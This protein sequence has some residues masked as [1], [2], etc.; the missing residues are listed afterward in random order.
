[1]IW[2]CYGEV[3]GEFSPGLIV[4]RLRQFDVTPVADLEETSRTKFY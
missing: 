4:Q 3:E 1:M 2:V